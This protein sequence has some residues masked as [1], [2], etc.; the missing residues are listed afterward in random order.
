[1]DAPSHL[2]V[3]FV[4]LDG[5]VTGGQVVAHQLM[6]GLRSAGHEALA[7]FP[8]EGP[9]VERVRADG[10]AVRV[11]PLR[12]TYRLDEAAGL[13]R[14]LRTE[15]VTLL[16]A[17]T[18]FVGTQLTRIAA[19]LARVPLVEHVHIEERFSGRPAVAAA[20]RLLA[21][22]TAAVPAATIAVSG[23]A[24]ASAIA[25]GA[26]PGRVVVVH[27]GVAVG[28]AVPPPPGQAL[29]LVC[30]ARLAHVKGQDVLIEALA[31]AGPGIEVGFAGADLEQGG[32]YRARLEARAAELGVAGSVRF[33]GHRN[34]LPALLDAA[35]AL[36]LPSRDEG[37]P[38]VALEALARA[39]AVVATA[40]GGLPELI[41]N[42][43]TGLLCAPGS[44]ESLALA[45]RRLRDE[46]G[47]RTRLGEAGHARVAEGFALEQMQART[48]A[49]YR[50]ILR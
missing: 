37:L 46:P 14:V 39:R 30:A 43:F 18:L 33:L 50:S 1:M 48:L 8:R 2:K 7:V 38:L 41:T 45:L 28:P 29:R 49:V 9:M 5:D 36:V 10:L 12:R 13:A 22:A 21:R 47:L 16:D 3:A 42:D 32:A 25:N 35:D 31:L 26:V 23:R 19:L 17:H 27:N 24:R 11:L 40:V 6:Q 15:R 20:Q 44:P 34:D 4:L